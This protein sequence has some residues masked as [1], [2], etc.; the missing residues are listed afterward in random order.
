VQYLGGALRTV[1]NST[2][3]AAGWKEYL[4][5]YQVLLGW[6][7]DTIEMV[8]A[9]FAWKWPGTTKAVSVLVL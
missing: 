7:N 1:L 5:Y 4:Q 2:L 3:S 8:Y 9:L 6:L